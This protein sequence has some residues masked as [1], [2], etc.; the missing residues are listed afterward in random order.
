MRLHFGSYGAA[1]VVILPCSLRGFRVNKNQDYV[2][3]ANSSW[4]PY[5]FIAVYFSNVTF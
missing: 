5:L 4:E 1:T 2:E 3:E